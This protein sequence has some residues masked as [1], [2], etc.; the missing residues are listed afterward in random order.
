MAEE[1]VD[2]QFLFP[3]AKPSFFNRLF[4]LY[5]ASAFNST[6]FQRQTIFGNF[7]IDCP[8]YY[9]ASAFSDQGLATY[10]LIFNAG[11]ELHGATRP[12]LHSTNAS[13]INNATLALIMKDWY[14]SFA[15][16]LDPNAVSYSGTPKPSWP[17]YDDAANGGF[18][19]MSVNYTMLGAVADP[20]AAPRCDFFHG[21]SYAV[22]N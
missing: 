10:K 14:T 22:R 11:T 4:S 20:D 9:M 15:T 6:F 3:Y 13:E 16:Q 12:F 17:K 7:I 1:Q 8:T 21:Q 18:N 19:I 2:L 5:P